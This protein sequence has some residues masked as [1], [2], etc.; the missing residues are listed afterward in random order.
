M[1]ASILSDDRVVDKQ[2]QT[3]LRDEAKL[4]CD[5]GRSQHDNVVQLLGICS[6]KGMR[7]VVL[8]LSYSTF[9]VL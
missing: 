7:V 4:L 6:Q 3:S 2:I 5:L 9:T 1:H 8:I